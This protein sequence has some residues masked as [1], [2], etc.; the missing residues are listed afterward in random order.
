MAHFN[1]RVEQTS[2]GP[3]SQA[4]PRGPAPSALHSSF[5]LL[6]PFSQ[7]LCL[8]GSACTRRGHCYSDPPSGAGGRIAICPLR[9][10]WWTRQD[11]GNRWAVGCASRSRAQ[12][13]LGGT[14]LPRPRGWFR[15]TACP[16]P[17]RLLFVLCC[18]LTPP[19]LAGGRS[20]PL[21]YQEVTGVQGEQN[22]MHHRLLPTLEEM[23]PSGQSPQ[24][25][26]PPPVPSSA[27]SR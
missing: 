18:T 26:C 2:A 14:E 9:R 7:L 8:K 15:S 17:G 23:K 21:F 11:Q 6:Y 5:M 1:P 13:A 25:G 12:A 24:C 10:G 20:V 16:S 19:A 27:G 3:G 4:L 22:L